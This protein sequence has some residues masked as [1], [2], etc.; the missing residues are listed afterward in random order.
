MYA[1]VP[2][3]ILVSV[4]FAGL[5][6]PACD[7]LLTVDFAVIVEGYVATFTDLTTT[8]LSDVHYWWDYG[9]GV[10]EHL[11]DYQYVYADTGTYNA[12]LSVSGSFDGDTCAGS[13]CR[14]VRIEMRPVPSG[15][16]VWPQPFLDAFTVEG[17]ELSGAVSAAMMDA[18]GRLVAEVGLQPTAPWG[19]VFPS[20]PSGWYALKFSGPFGVK[21][22]RVLKQ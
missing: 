12:C 17:T 5:A 2:L 6:Q 10:V 16:L 11:G 20:L 18:C 14:A 19:F 22:V 9:D 15:L 21:V 4:P 3:I 8:D 7:T 1:S 13:A